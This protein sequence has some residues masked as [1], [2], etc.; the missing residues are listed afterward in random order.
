ML[1]DLIIFFSGI[2][3]GYI[4]TKCGYAD[5]IIEKAHKK[6]VEHRAKNTHIK[7]EGLLF[8]ISSFGWGDP[9]KKSE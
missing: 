8:G 3:C 6:Y 7:E 1:C 5:I 9:N 4:L 2:V